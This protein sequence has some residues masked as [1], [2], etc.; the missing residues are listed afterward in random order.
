[1]LGHNGRARAHG[2]RVVT[3][4]HCLRAVWV[5]AEH[6]D[7]P[8][9]M[10]ATT[11]ATAGAR[12]QTVVAVARCHGW[13]VGVMRVAAARGRSCGDGRH[14]AETG[15]SSRTH[16][17]AVHVLVACDAWQR[18]S[19]T[20]LV[21]RARGRRWCR[22]VPLTVRAGA[23]Y[24]KFGSARMATVAVLKVGVAVSSVV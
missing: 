14:G 1:M 20:L 2:H 23:A 5:V 18:R 12:A 8:E 7:V 19:R 21:R 6:A 22:R 15:R 24:D 13:T 4:V 11:T 3:T 16:A 10:S 9:E 17:G